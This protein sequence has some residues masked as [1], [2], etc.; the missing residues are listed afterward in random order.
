MIGKLSASGV[1]MAAML[2]ALAPA[3]SWAQYNSFEDA[4]LAATA[5]AEIVA[6]REWN[7]PDFLERKTVT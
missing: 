7:R 1:V 3:P 5:L 4:W 6:G 2:V